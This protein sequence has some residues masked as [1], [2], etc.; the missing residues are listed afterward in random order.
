MFTAH[1]PTDTTS[2][3]TDFPGCNTEI[4]FLPGGVVI[5]PYQENNTPLW[6]WHEY[7]GVTRINTGGHALYQ[8]HHPWFDANNARF[9][10]E[11]TN[12]S[13]WAFACDQL[14]PGSGQDI[15]FGGNITLLPNGPFFW[16]GDTDQIRDWLAPLVL[17]GKVRFLHRREPGLQIDILWS[18]AASPIYCYCPLKM[19]I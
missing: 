10:W 19:T 2:D 6:V 13:G 1:I 5:L 18:M 11:S 7:H 3:Q 16:G 15:R 9:S 12:P 4:R 17:D 8:L 14:P